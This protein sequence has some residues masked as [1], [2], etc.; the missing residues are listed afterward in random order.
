MA[1]PAP[2]KTNEELPSPK[3]GP[4]QLSTRQV[5]SDGAVTTER[6]A[7]R[8]ASSR[9]SIMGTLSDPRICAYRGLARLQLTAQGGLRDCPRSCHLATGWSVRLPS[10]HPS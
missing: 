6:D 9:V 4:T 2:A 8:L 5:R 1:S 10:Q 7:C 3:R